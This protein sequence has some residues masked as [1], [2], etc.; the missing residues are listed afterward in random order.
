MCLVVAFEGGAKA[1]SIFWEIHLW[2]NKSLFTAP[3]VRVHFVCVL[4][5]SCTFSV[6]CNSGCRDAPL[7]ESD[8]F[9]FALL[10]LSPNFLNVDSQFN[11]VLRMRYFVIR[12]KTFDYYLIGDKCMF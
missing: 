4:H 11:G 12:K 10:L 6:S 3:S 7:V 9:V 5:L 1:Q 2:I 8:V